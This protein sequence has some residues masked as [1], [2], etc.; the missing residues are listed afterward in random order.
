MTTAEPNQKEHDPVCHMDIDVRDAKGR[1]DYDGRTYFF[2]A[3]GC[4]RQFD[5]DPEAALRAEDTYDHS[6]PPLET[7]GT[8]E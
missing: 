6:Q 2:C 7:M 8:I 5:A 4:K 3:E 1:T